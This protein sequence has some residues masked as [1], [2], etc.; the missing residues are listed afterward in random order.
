MTMPLY[1]PPE[2]IIK[3]RADFA[4]RGVARGRPAVVLS[5]ADGVLLAAANTSR[6]LRK[7]SEIYDRMAFAAVGKW[8]EFEALRVAGIRYADLR[9]YS[10]DR[11]DVTARGLAGAYAQTI[12]AAFTGDPKPL[13]VELAVA[14]VGASQVSDAVFHVRF[15]GSVSDELPWA[16]LGGATP[17][18]RQALAEGWRP[19][20]SLAQ[21][22]SLARL[23]LAEGAFS[24][25]G[26]GRAG[27]AAAAGGDDGYEVGLLVRASS[28]RA[29]ARLGSLP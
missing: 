16:V 28:G 24:G 4:K 13:E 9:G 5:T 12:A 25:N 19:G 20:L 1:V 2:Q 29:F 17:A 11:T 3:D 21:A 27:G 26:E 14:E 6:A 18:G 22:G 10:Y 23:A 8:S 15:D 7:L